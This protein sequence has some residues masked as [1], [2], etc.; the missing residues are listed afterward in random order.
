MKQKFYSD[1]QVVCRE[2]SVLPSF[3]TGAQRPPPFVGNNYYCESANP[4]DDFA[5]N[6][7]Y[8]ADKLWDGEQCATEGTCCS[9]PPWF[10]VQLPSHSSEDI[11]VRIC[12]DERTSNEDTP[13]ELLE[14]YIR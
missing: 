5:N 3:H 7:L 10:S 8:R 9:G 13:I 14:I 11:E 4:N 6:V 12:G 2:D 1:C